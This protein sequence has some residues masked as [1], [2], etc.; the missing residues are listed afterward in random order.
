M[1][2][3]GLLGSDLEID[4]CRVRETFSFGVWHS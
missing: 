3:A 2:W 4:R 1:R